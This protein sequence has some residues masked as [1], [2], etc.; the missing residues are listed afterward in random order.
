MII[1]DYFSPASD[2]GFGR[3]KGV[4]ASGL[5]LAARI[6]FIKLYQG[7]DIDAVG[8]NIGVVSGVEGLYLSVLL[9]DPLHVADILFEYFITG[10]LVIKGAVGDVLKGK[11]RF[12]ARQVQFPADDGL[13]EGCK[14]M[15]VH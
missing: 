9:Q 2:R 8:G 7:Q 6:I 13:T 4:T 14:C 5:G 3:F 12:S 1:Q 15:K 10:C 11:L